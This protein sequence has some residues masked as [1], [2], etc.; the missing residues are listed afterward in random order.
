MRTIQ[1]D[2]DYND[3]LILED[4]LAEYLDRIDQGEKDYPEMQHERNRVVAI[5]VQLGHPAEAFEPA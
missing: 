5:L 3:V 1:L 2:E 4:C